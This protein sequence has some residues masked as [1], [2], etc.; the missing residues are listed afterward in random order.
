MGAFDSNHE[1]RFIWIRR[2]CGKMETND[3]IERYIAKV[4]E[5]L[6][7]KNR[8]DITLELKTLLYDDL[9]ER[10]GGVPPTKEMTAD[11]LRDYGKPEAIAAKYQPER[12]LIGPQLLPIYQ[13]V[14]TV[15]MIVITVL[16]TIPV[17]ITLISNGINDVGSWFF[18]TIFDLSQSLLINFA[19]ITIAFAVVERVKGESW[20]EEPDEE[21]WDPYALAPV[22]NPNRI[23]RSE[24]IAGIVLSICAIVI[25]NFFPHWLGMAENP[26]KTNVIIPILTPG[27]LAYV[28]WLT[29]YWVLEILLKLQLLRQGEWRP[30]TR[31]MEFALGLFSLVINYQ[32][33]TGGPITTMAWLN[34]IIRFGLGIGIIVGVFESLYRLY[35]IIRPPLIVSVSDN[36]V[37]SKIA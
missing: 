12:Y 35:R 16:Y 7:R 18:K 15:V 19:W 27:F 17:A 2:E 9:E 1:P 4:G 5:N 33:L 10:A 23:K 13:V 22:E 36:N 3:L 26:D 28:P 29:V 6:P 14:I 30:A 34:L 20:I 8:E 32:I 11:L 21:D 37:R 31:W 25:F 24:L